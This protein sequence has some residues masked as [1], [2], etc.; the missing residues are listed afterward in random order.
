MEEFWYETSD[1]KQQM[2]DKYDS[3]KNDKPAKKYAKIII[4]AALC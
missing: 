1:V 4:I 2:F 3:V